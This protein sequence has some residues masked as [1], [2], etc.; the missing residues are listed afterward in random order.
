MG[1]FLVWLQDFEWWRGKISADALRITR[2]L[3][4]ILL[5]IRLNSW[6][7]HDADHQIVGERERGQKRR[8][9]RWQLERNWVRIWRAFYLHSQRFSPTTILDFIIKFWRVY[10]RISL[11]FQT[12]LCK[13][14]KYPIV[15]DV[16]KKFDP[17]KF[18]KVY[19]ILSYSC[20]IQH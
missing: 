1:F 14:I 13:N 2:E 9:E 17:F 5:R 15:R 4:K 11:C 19:L 7:D 12:Y 20:R 18:L 10:T 3:R 8:D 6:I 16:T